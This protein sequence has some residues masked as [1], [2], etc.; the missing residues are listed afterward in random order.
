MANIMMTDVC[1]LSCPY[2]FANEF[3]NKDK[4]EITE[5]AFDQAVEFIV[6]DGSHSVVGLIGGEP[7]VHSRF[8]YFMRKLILNDKVKGITVYTNGILINKFWD[9]VCHPKT[10]LLINCN[11][12]K[13]I[14]KKQYEILSDNLDVLINQKMCDDRVTLGINMYG[15]N[16]EYQ[17]MIDLLTKFNQHH[18]RVS[19]TV[20]NMDENRNI[21]AHTYFNAMK[22]RMF[23]FFHALLSRGIIPNF[24]CNKIPSCLVT[25]EELQ[26]FN[27]Y[28]Q[29]DFIKQ[30]I[31]NSNIV[32]NTVKCVPVIDIRQDLVAV[33]CFGLSET[34]KQNIKNFA[35]ISELY[36]FYLRSIDAYAYNT[37]YSK[38]CNDC[39][40]R[41]VMKCSGGCLAYKIK[42]INNMNEISKKMMEE[43]E[44]DEF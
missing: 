7:T 24:D 29:D 30:N 39:H 36:N 9:V 27:Q 17:Y 22:P 31:N 25:Q 15:E 19:I 33:R 40:L 14:G 16:F 12:P 44:H 23:E 11:S 18:V 32:T 8:E 6:G 1:N 26:C 28:L 13:D 43:F 10:H 5:E 38:K 20:P 3:V 34:T 42:Q 37:S 35:N 41:L 21:D 2:C 4:N